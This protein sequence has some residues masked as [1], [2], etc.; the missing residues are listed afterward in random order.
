MAVRH[1]GCDANRTVQCWFCQIHHFFVVV[2]CVFRLLQIVCIYFTFLLLINLLSIVGQLYMFRAEIPLTSRNF[3]VKLLQAL[4]ED[5]VLLTEVFWVVFNSGS[6]NSCVCRGKYQNGWRKQ[7]K[8]K[9]CGS[10]GMHGGKRMMNA[11][12]LNWI[13]SSVC[14]RISFFTFYKIG[15]NA[16]LV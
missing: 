12:R 5:V 8:T 14:W 7:E 11:K 4:A 9:E 3:G 13:E 6:L 16:C 15:I 2:V 10:S 1:N